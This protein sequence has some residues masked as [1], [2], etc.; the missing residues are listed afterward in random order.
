MTGAIASIQDLL[1]HPS[2]APYVAIEHSPQ[3][4]NKPRIYISNLVAKLTLDHVRHKFRRI[5]A[6]IIKPNTMT[7]N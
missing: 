1:D 2:L 7:L 4:G 6:N 3:T 5:T